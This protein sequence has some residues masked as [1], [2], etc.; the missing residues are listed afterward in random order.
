VT[1]SE[2]LPRAA[3][4]R[5]QGW[6]SRG[7]REKVRPPVAEAR[8][9]TAG[10]QARP[11]TVKLARQ[12]TCC[13]PVV[14]AHTRH[15]WLRNGRSSPP[16]GYDPGGARPLAMAVWTVVRSRALRRS[17]SSPS[18]PRALLAFL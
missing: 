2:V 1:C 14:G 9:T 7:S 17:T 5:Y 11:P 12:P 3:L 15:P 8:A 10:E 6:S 18:Q 13:V 16:H 4:V